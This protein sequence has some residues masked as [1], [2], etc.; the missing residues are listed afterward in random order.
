MGGIAAIGEAVR[1]QGLGLAGVLVLPGEDDDQVRARWSALPEDVA[2]VIL[3][4]RAAQ[5]LSE[6]GPGPLRVVMPG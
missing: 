5:A 2:V 3:T 6:V 1:V 4:P